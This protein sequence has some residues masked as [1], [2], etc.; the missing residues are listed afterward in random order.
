M[1]HDVNLRS[2]SCHSDGLRS[3]RGNSDRRL[4]QNRNKHTSRLSP[5][6]GSDTARASLDP[7][8]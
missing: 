4:Q 2:K 8:G 1:P 7:T 3:V 6:F 5:V